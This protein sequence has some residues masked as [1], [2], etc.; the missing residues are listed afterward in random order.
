MP[1]VVIMAT[2]A[3]PWA[4]RIVAVTAGVR[5]RFVASDTGADGV[6]RGTKGVHGGGVRLTGDY[7]V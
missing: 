7:R 4:M 5:L 1:A 2:V 6:L 3:E